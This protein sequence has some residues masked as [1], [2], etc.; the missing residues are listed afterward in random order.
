[1]TDL[2]KFTKLYKSLGIKLNKYKE[3]ETIELRFGY[4]SNS[5]DFDINDLFYGYNGFHTCI[6][7]DLDEKFIKQGFWE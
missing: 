7:F 1:M 6:I 4:Y 3:K 2:M 5:D